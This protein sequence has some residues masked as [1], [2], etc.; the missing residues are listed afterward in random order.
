[1]VYYCSAILATQHYYIGGHGFS[2]TDL[3]LSW[4]I[5]QVGVQVVINGI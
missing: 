1:M 2:G 5:L 4:M 3:V